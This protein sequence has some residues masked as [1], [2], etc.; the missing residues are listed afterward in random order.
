MS[1]NATESSTGSEQAVASN[2]ASPQGTGDGGDKN[3]WALILSIISPVV[4]AITLIS[5]FSIY[6]ERVDLLGEVITPEFLI[7]YGGL[8]E[9]VKELEE[10][11]TFLQGLVRDKYL[12]TDDK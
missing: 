3:N 6:K 12:K 11:V 9:S 1:D 4:M 7:Q 2:S 8:L 10:E 5:G